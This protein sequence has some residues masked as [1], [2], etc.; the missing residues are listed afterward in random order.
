[1]GRIEG[2]FVHREKFTGETENTLDISCSSLKR[3]GSLHCLAKGQTVEVPIWPYVPSASPKAE[4][5][6]EFRVVASRTLLPSATLRLRPDRTA[7]APPHAFGVDDIL[8]AL[9]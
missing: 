1:M 6:F 2:L 5:F 4:T 7:A 9:W 8:C 3:L